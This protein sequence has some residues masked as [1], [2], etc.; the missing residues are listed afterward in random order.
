MVSQTLYLLDW[1]WLVKVFYEAEPKDADRILDILD[2][3]GCS[4]ETLSSA[5][6]LLCYGKFNSGLTFSS[7]EEQCSLVVI[8]KTNSADEF[9]NTFDHEKRHLSIHIADSYHIDVH[10]EEYAYLAGAIAQQMFKVAKKFM[11]D[12]CREKAQK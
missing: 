6:K 10:S 12:C 5:E 8:G 2:G 7:P 11:C 3:M 4:R 9:A 1:D